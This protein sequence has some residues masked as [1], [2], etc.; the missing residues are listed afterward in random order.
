MSTTR[1]PRQVWTPANP[2]PRAVAKVSNPLPVPDQCPH[3]GG[4][5]TIENNSKIYG[6]E[7]GSWPYAVLCSEPGKCGA[8]VGVHPKTGIPLGTMATKPM[9][10]ARQEAKKYFAP[11]YDGPNATMT[12]TEAYAWLAGA[13][14]IANVDHCH[15]GWFDIEQ[16]AAVVAAVKARPA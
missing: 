6:R 1:K 8:Y 15:V 9:R 12:R 14:G 4:A 11:L 13:M 5:V 3:C 16:C 10:V 7:Y 2:S